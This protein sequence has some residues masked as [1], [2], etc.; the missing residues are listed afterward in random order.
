[1]RRLSYTHDFLQTRRTARRVRMTSG[2][3]TAS[4]FYSRRD[5][6]T[7]TTYLTMTSDHAGLSTTRSGPICTLL[8]IMERP[9]IGCNRCRDQEEA[10]YISIHSM[11]INGIDQP[12]CHPLRGMQGNK[13]DAI[14]ALKLHL[15]PRFPSLVA[16][17]VMRFHVTVAITPLPSWTDKHKPSIRSRLCRACHASEIRVVGYA[18]DRKRKLAS[19]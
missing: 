3:A 10:E 17:A 8:S 19:G 9:F 5:R 2:T 1:M 12:P 16:F 15:P 13:A 6:R 14:T 11:P 4:L 18:G 7:L